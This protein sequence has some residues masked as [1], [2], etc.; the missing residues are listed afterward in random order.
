MKALFKKT[1]L[2]GITFAAAS[3]LSL[4]TVFVC[5]TTAAAEVAAPTTLVLSDESTVRLVDPQG[6]RFSASVSESEYQAIEAEY[7]AEN[8]TKGII[9]A[10][11]DSY[12]GE[13]SAESDCSKLNI[14]CPVSSVE[15]ETVVFHGV[16]HHIKES[17]YDTPFNA[18]AYIVANR[19]GNSEYF[20]SNTLT[21][22]TYFNACQEELF[23]KEYEHG[24][25]Q[26]QRLS[27][28]MDSVVEASDGEITAEVDSAD[29]KVY[30]GDALKVKCTF[31]GVR[32][33]C[34]ISTTDEYFSLTEGS[35]VAMKEGETTVNVCVGSKET[36]LSVQILPIQ[37]ENI[38][39]ATLLSVNPLIKVSYTRDSEEL[40]AGADVGIN[41]V[42]PAQKLSGFSKDALFQTNKSLVA[43][44]EYCIT[45]AYKV[46]ENAFGGFTSGFGY[47]MITNLVVDG[48][49]VATDGKSADAQ[50]IIA[51]SDN[52]GATNREI[53]QGT[54]RYTP[55]ET[56]QNAQFKIRV[57]PG[58]YVDDVNITLYRFKIIDA[59]EISGAKIESVLDTTGNMRV[60]L[61]DDTQ[62]L[63]GLNAKAGV[64]LYNDVEQKPSSGSGPTL[65]FNKKLKANTQY[66][67]MYDVKKVS[68]TGTNA[69]SFNTFIY[70]KYATAKNG[71][72]YTY[73]AANGNHLERLQSGKYACAYEVEGGAANGIYHCINTFTPTMDLDALTMKISL[74]NGLEI[75]YDIVITNVVC[76]ESE[77]FLIDSYETYYS[78]AHTNIFNATQDSD[79]LV[80]GATMGL[81]WH[82]ND[83][84][85]ATFGTGKTLD[86]GTYTLSYQVISF[87]GEENP[88]FLGAYNERVTGQV[89]TTT[90]GT[91]T[92]TDVTPEGS[93][94]KVF[95]VEVEF[96]FDASAKLYLKAYNVTGKATG[97]FVITNLTL[98]SVASAE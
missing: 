94:Y 20:Y 44:R 86:A 41:V 30:L 23:E 58:E 49:N 96:T 43:G 92:V 91:K 36:D 27:A 17:H 34:R 77:S 85:W 48:E 57:A 32:V 16:M 18:R 6:L 69:A 24:E 56:V 95:N 46:N 45:Y 54:V 29:G 11:A 81:E 93:A 90:S 70:F 98:A 97:G 55:T 80:N 37:A 35:Y 38:S 2:F 64:R 84:F 47:R 19:D 8:V 88:L 87:A 67:V 71:Y 31:N 25:E 12:S 13:L 33:P 26:L 10:K 65:S 21:G 15:S 68:A 1:C 42:V 9:I 76:F 3:L 51:T 89:E 61:T 7:G 40:G 5:R 79:K 60:E 39:N 83:S 66:T 63:S 59:T 50:N 62:V 78:G 22:V 73:N 74:H 14:A 82:A 75:A 72:T 28:I 4:A 53:Y 52:T